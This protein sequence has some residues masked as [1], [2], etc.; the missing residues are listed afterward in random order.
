MVASSS[1]SKAGILGRA[2][3]YK[4]LCA[5]PDHMVAELI[6]GD[7]WVSPRPVV[8]HSHTAGLLAAELIPPFG[9]GRGGPG[10]WLILPECEI[11]FDGD[12]LVPDLAGWRRGNLKE[13]ASEA[14]MSQAP[15]WACEIT[16]PS[17]RKLD[18]V[19]KFGI[20]AREGVGH[21]WLVEPKKKKLEVFKLAA[22]VYVPILDLSDDRT[23]AAEP[24][25]AVP[26]PL[27]RIW[28]DR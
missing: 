7:L 15:D 2:A 14:F 28:S 25:E 21:L 4:D 5:V 26:F 20:Y 11:H 22:G 8:R 1:M 27:Q 19:L 13:M 9:Q 18:R 6:G 16:S 17:T 23:A 10:G 24:F 12:V 3:T